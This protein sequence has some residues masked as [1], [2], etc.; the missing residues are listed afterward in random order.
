MRVNEIAFYHCGGLGDGNTIEG[1]RVNEIAFSHCGGLGDGNAIVCPFSEKKTGLTHF[2][3][4]AF[5]LARKVLSM[6]SCQTY[7]PPD[8]V[9]CYQTL[10][11]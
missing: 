11:G 7:L 8:G 10:Q 1:G 3:R 5:T 9:H 4:G 6:L 2:V